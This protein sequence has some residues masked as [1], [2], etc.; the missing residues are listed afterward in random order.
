MPVTRLSPYFG[1][2]RPGDKVLVLQERDSL[3]AV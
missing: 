2:E 1:E 3:A